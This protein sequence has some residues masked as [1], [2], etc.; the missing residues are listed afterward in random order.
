MKTRWTLAA[1]LLFVIAAESHAD[2][3]IK[4]T[5]ASDG[6]AP[7]PFTMY[8]K[9]GQMRMDSADGGENVSMLIRPTADGSHEYVFLD[10]GRRQAMT[11]PRA[12]AD[13]AERSVSAK[14]DAVVRVLDDEVDEGPI[15]G[16]PVSKVEY[17]FAGS[18]SLPVPDGQEIPDELAEM[19]SIT[20][21][22]EGTSLVAQ[23]ADGAD[24]LAEFY[25]AIGAGM[26]DVDGAPG[27]TQGLVSGMLMVAAHGVP[28]KTTTTTEI[29]IAVNASGP[30][31]A[32][33]EA[34]TSRM[35]NMKSTST[36]EV[37]DISTD[38]VDAALFY[39]GGLPEGYAVETLAAP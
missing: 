37:T 9:D 33:I 14:T 23:D 29:K 36:S 6:D 10:H 28:L 20:V 25:S 5:S 3:T 15:L 38:P 16:Y 31:R 4:G 1:P 32:M 7:T 19:M 39:G 11:M 35:P 21:Q 12:Q 2:V 30:M 34:M 26:G 18:G 27:L 24:E 17:A 8:L 22:V 13:Q